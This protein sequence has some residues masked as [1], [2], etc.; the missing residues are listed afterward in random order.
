MRGFPQCGFNLACIL[1]SCFAFYKDIAGEAD[2]VV[3]M[4]D[5]EN[6]AGIFTCQKILFGHT[7]SASILSR[8]PTL[9]KVIINQ[10]KI[11]LYFIILFKA[12]IFQ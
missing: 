4:T 1:I 9:D 2:F 8:K 5:Y 7:K 3:F 10:V 6:Y 12:V 11:K